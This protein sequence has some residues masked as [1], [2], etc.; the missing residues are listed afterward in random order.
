MKVFLKMKEWSYIPQRKKYFFLDFFFTYKDPLLPLL[1]D[2][3][4]CNNNHE[5]YISRRSSGNKTQR[6]NMMTL[7]LFDIYLENN[8]RSTE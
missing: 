3:H 5:T 2:L 8:I 1:S 6:E 7:A 4:I